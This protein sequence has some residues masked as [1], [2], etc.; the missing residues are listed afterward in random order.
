MS[1][2]PPAKLRRV[3]RVPERD[4]AWIRSTQLITDLAAAVREL[5]E[6]AVDAGA[7]V[8]EVRVSAQQAAVSVTDNGSG[9]TAS[10][11]HELLTR[12]YTTSKVRSASE[13]TEVETYGFRGE[14]LHSLGMLSLL[15]V[16]SRTLACTV[17]C[18][19]IVQGGEDISTQSDTAPGGQP[20]T[21]VTVRNLFYNCPVR[22]SVVKDRGHYTEVARSREAL[23]ELA[24]AHPTVAFNLVD[25]EKGRAV[26]RCQR[27]VDLPTRARD[28][29]GAPK[30][31]CMRAV[32]HVL[33]SAVRE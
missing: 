20:G 15:E 7:T 3:E 12:R 23:Q 26:W 6:N 29:F 16:R 1:A 11:M 28:L 2:A 24:L 31:A 13:L 25:D 4:A 19:K 30:I 10:D 27:A 14:A 21:T 5:V 8:I 22:R 17:A 32:A 18:T 9:I 33:T